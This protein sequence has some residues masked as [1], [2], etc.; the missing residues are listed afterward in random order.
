MR[1]FVWV[2]VSRDFLLKKVYHRWGSRMRLVCIVAI[3]RVKIIH[4]IF[5]GCRLLPAGTAF[6]VLAGASSA[7]GST[8][9]LP[10]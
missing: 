5:S 3:S 8:G 9:K 4:Y 10:C 2:L 7:V 6:G 1:V